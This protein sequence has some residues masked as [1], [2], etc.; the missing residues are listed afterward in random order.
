MRWGSVGDVRL[1]RPALLPV[2]PLR[3]PS[4]FACFR[5]CFLGTRRLMRRESLMGILGAGRWRPPLPQKEFLKPRVTAPQEPWRDAGRPGL[6]PSS[7]SPGSH[8][9]LCACGLCEADSTPQAQGR[10]RDSGLCRLEHPI[11]VAWTVDAGWAVGWACLEKRI[12][13]SE[14]NPGE[15][16]AWKGHGHRKPEPQDKEGSGPEVSV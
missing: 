5:R 14:H 15:M 16:L 10:S 9:A 2:W 13:F 4:M 7:G 8:P 3:G 12:C 6:L 11:P 1:R